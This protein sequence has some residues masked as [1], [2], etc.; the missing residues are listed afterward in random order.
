MITA[1]TNCGIR[2][3]RL[4]AS[5][6][7]EMINAPTVGEA[8]CKCFANMKTGLK[9]GLQDFSLSQIVTLGTALV[10]TGSIAVVGASVLYSKGSKGPSDDQ[11]SL[12]V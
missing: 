9:N 7:N 5:I 10:V 3:F 1:C 2:A 6:W 4:A 12:P 8:T 11:K